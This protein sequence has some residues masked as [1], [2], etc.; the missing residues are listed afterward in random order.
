MTFGTTEAVTALRP[1]Y[2]LV[3][4]D[5]FGRYPEVRLV[6]ENSLKS[7]NNY[8]DSLIRG[9]PVCSAK[10][11][12]FYLRSKASPSEMLSS[13]SDGCRLKTV[14]IVLSHN[15]PYSLVRCVLETCSLSTESLLKT[16]SRN[17]TA[18]R[19]RV[20]TERSGIY[21]SSELG[22]EGWVKKLASEALKQRKLYRSACAESES[23]VEAVKN[24]YGIREVK[25]DSPW[26]ILHF[27]GCLKVFSDQLRGYPEFS[28]ILRGRVCSF[29]T[30]LQWRWLLY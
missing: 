1:F 27:Q 15:D 14:S 16:E 5:F 9:K 26:S 2:F 13:D 7:L 19:F 25:W 6:N 23:I 20:S 4:P 10:K 18:N 12:T 24:A 29:S 28:S 8:L 22:P 3:H 21:K 17:A 30:L 11:L